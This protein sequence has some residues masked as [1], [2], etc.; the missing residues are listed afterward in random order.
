MCNIRFLKYITGSDIQIDKNHL[1]MSKW[2][3]IVIFLI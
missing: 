2:E 3:K 1:E